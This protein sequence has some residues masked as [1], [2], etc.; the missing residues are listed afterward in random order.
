ML[1]CSADSV[2]PQGINVYDRKST[3]LLFGYLYT[4]S[5]PLVVNEFVLSEH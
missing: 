2:A 1:L 4:D 5:S 3:V